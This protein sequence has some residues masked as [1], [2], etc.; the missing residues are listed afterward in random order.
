MTASI[1]LLFAPAADG[2]PLHGAKMKLIAQL[3]RLPVPAIDVYPTADQIESVGDFIL[4]CT[5]DEVNEQEQ[6]HHQN[7]K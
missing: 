6:Q 2:N 3:A 1:E 5:A 4:G 7:E